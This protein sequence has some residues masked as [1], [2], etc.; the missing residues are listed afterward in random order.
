MT[1]NCNTLLLTNYL[2]PRTQYHAPRCSLFTSLLFCALSRSR[3]LLL[4]A[5]TRYTRSRSF[6]ALDPKWNVECRPIESATLP[7][8]VRRNRATLEDTSVILLLILSKE[9][10]LVPTRS[11]HPLTHAARRHK[12]V[13]RYHRRRWPG[14]HVS[15]AHGRPE[16]RPSACSR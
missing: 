11:S 9:R 6:I 12:Y 8:S 13:S 10:I 4:H 14:R 2:V 5:V 16:W 1:R 3:S 7:S 15:C